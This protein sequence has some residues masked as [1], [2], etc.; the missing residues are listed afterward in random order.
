MVGISHRNEA[1]RRDTQVSGKR[2]LFE[3]EKFQSLRQSV[4]LLVC[5]K[6]WRVAEVLFV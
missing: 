3:E 2:P 1:H 5:S 4:Y 6:N